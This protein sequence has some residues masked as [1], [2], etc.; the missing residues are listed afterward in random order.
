[1]H[2]LHLP[3]Q[4]LISSITSHTIHH[5]HDIQPIARVA[6]SDSDSDG[7]DH[8]YDVP[9]NREDILNK[10][11]TEGVSTYATKLELSHY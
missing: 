3:E 10:L 7:S 5:V 11:V 9:P 2:D 4:S 1:M 6:S 8:I